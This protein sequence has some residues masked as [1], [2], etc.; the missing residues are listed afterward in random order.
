MSGMKKI[1][2][3]M[4]IGMMAAL[5]GCAGKDVDPVG[6]A[7]DNIVS[8]DEIS[9][10]GIPE[11][12]PSR[13]EISLN[14]EISGTSETEIT[15]IRDENAESIPASLE[16]V[17]AVGEY[18]GFVPFDA[19]ENGMWYE[20]AGDGEERMAVYEEN[21]E[22]AA[23]EL[24]EFFIEI[25]ETDTEAGRYVYVTNRKRTYASPINI[26]VSTA[27]S[28]DEYSIFNQRTISGLAPYG[29]YPVTYIEFHSFDYSEEEDR[30]IYE[31]ATL[32]L[33]ADGQ[34]L[35]LKDG[36][37]YSLE[38]TIQSRIMSGDFSCMEDTWSSDM[39][40]YYERWSK[41]D[42]YEWRLIDLNGDG[43]DDLI[44]QER[45]VVSQDRQWHRIIAI[46][47]CKEDS[48]VLFDFDVNDATEYSFCGPTGE[49]MYNYYSY[50]VSI[51]FDAYEHYYYDVE[52][53][54]ITDY[55]MLE[56][57][58]DSSMDGGWE[59]F[60]EYRPN[61]LEEHPEMDKDGYYYS[62]IPVD[63]ET[64]EDMK[65]EFMSYEEFKEIFEEVTGIEFIGHDYSRR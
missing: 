45:R 35:L 65:R 61:W 13:N 52:W 20:M 37:Y 16:G 40:D 38:H 2:L 64:G 7:V 3:V 59:E 9:E 41:A 30:V 27:V 10:N 43:I 6:Q 42:S 57:E 47:A 14:G 5:A 17:W 60:L 49:L 8:E 4:G 23:A 33:T 50:G 12:A 26:T 22:R 53:N 24:P 55:T 58:I 29:D 56:T 46:F 15:D 44:L 11:N 21:K 31:P 39:S 48:A 62:I 36:A 34:F 19:Y 1:L 32:I 18:I 54:R 28:E 63:P 51:D 25:R